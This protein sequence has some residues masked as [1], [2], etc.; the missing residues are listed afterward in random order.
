MVQRARLRYG[1]DLF[2]QLVGARQKWH[3][4]A[5]A[6]AVFTFTVSQNFVGNSTG[7][8]AGLLPFKILSTKT[9][10]VSGRCY[11]LEKISRERRSVALSV[12]GLGRNPPRA[13]VLNQQ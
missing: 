7:R 2:D 12:P 6:F 10:F 3:S 1:F 9:L 13:R 5:N 8:S 11:R 4:D